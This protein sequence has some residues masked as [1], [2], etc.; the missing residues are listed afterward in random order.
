MV[1]C[2]ILK[3]CYYL[4]WKWPIWDQEIFNEINTVT[5]FNLF[6]S[7]M[8]I[9]RNC[10]CNCL[11]MRSIVAAKHEQIFNGYLL[12]LINQKPLHRR[13]FASSHPFWLMWRNLIKKY[14]ISPILQFSWA[15]IH[16]L[17]IFTLYTSENN[18][19]PFGCLVF[20]RAAKWEH[21][22]EMV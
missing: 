3:M 19:K 14:A 7:C 16:F 17:P 15:L 13:S 12:T 22:P 21:W 6:P 8:K 11:A 2:L 1:S 10:T 4:Y 18:R 5:Y 20:L 9:V